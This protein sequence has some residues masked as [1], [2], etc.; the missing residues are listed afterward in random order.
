[1]TKPESSAEELIPLTAQTLLSL[2][3][4]HAAVVERL[5]LTLVPI[6]AVPLCHYLRGTPSPFLWPSAFCATRCELQSHQHASGFLF[7]LSPDVSLKATLSPGSKGLCWPTPPK[8]QNFLCL[9]L[10]HACSLPRS[11][12][13]HFLTLADSPAIPTTCAYRYREKEVPGAPLRQQGLQWQVPRAATTPGRV[14]SMTEPITEP[15]EP[16]GNVEVCLRV[17]HFR[18]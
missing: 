7:L 15:G 11:F 6:E 16:L 1:M 4:H 10:S 12:S 18:A 17:R 2:P 8:P 14:R 3:A 9:H 5:Q 13:A